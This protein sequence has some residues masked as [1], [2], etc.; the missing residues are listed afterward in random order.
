MNKT[1]QD[2]DRVFPPLPEDSPL[3]EAHSIDGIY[4][5]NNA[6]YEVR[7]LPLKEA[8]HPDKKLEHF[9]ED[10]GDPDWPYMKTESDFKNFTDWLEDESFVKSL[11]IAFRA[12]GDLGVSFI[13]PLF[14]IRNFE[15]PIA[16]GWL[17]NRIYLKDEN[18]RDFGWNVIYT[19]SAS[20][21]IDGYFSAGLE[22]DVEDVPD[23]PDQT[24]SRT[25]F[26]SETGIKWRLNMA[27]S[28]LK[29]LTKVTDFWGFRMGIQY[30]GNF[31]DFDHIG[32][33]VE[34]GAGTW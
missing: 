33:I 12:D 4:A 8:A 28:P 16:G 27:H 1:R 9:I 34:I 19:P 7:T 21:W 2:E 14:I 20:R 18:L 13:F 26:T 5:P 31:T 6:I 29:F 23:V 32:Y 22:I 10:K 24:T 30:K 3:R 15:D 25:V 17:V 11:S